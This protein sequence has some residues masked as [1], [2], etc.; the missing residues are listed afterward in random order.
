MKCEKCKG[1]GCIWVESDNGIGYVPSPC[2][3][4]RGSG[5]IIVHNSEWFISLDNTKKAD[6]L[7]KICRQAVSS[8]MD[9]NKEMLS[10][11]FWKDWLAEEKKEIKK[12]DRMNEGKSR[13]G[14]C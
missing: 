12:S 10:E 13:K 6:F 14:I 8:Y 5:E 3:V 4:C 11:V 1:D 7:A 2:P 9:G